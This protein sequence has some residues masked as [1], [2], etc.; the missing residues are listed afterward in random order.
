MQFFSEPIN[1]PMCAGVIISRKKRVL[2]S[3]GTQDRWREIDGKVHIPVSGIGGGQEP[4]ES[5]IDCARREAEEELGCPVILMHSPTTYVQNEHGQM[6]AERFQAMPAPLFYHRRER[7][8]NAPYADDLPAGNI[9]HLGAFR[10][11]LDSTELA[12]KDIPAVIWIKPDSL[13]QFLKGV[14]VKDLSLIGAEL[15]TSTDI[16]DDAVLYIEPNGTEEFMLKA[17]QQFPVQW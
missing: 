3:L 15:I 7:D 9:V 10:A 12:P 11:R 2:F 5:F 17:Q 4:G 14:A 1:E 6:E 16:A 8:K 13:A